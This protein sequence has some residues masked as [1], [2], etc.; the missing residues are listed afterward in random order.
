M[1]HMCLPTLEAVCSQWVLDALW[2]IWAVPVNLVKGVAPIACCDEHGA[3]HQEMAWGLTEGGEWLSCQ[4]ETEKENQEE[5][6]N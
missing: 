4:E 3:T 2:G 5:L 1:I 6:E